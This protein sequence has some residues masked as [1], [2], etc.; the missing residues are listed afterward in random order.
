MIPNH[1]F[2]PKG[3]IHHRRGFAVTSYNGRDIAYILNVEGTNDDFNLVIEIMTRDG[4]S[5]FRETSIIYPVIPY[6]IN[7]ADPKMLTV[8]NTGNGFANQNV[9]GSP[10]FNPGMTLT[11][12]ALNVTQPFGLLTPQG[13]IQ[14]NVT[15]DQLTTL[16]QDTAP[17][18]WKVCN[19][20]TTIDSATFINPG[21]LVSNF[22]YKARDTRAS[23]LVQNNNNTDIIYLSVTATV[24][25]TGFEGRVTYYDSEPTKTTSVENG[26]YKVYTYSLPV[27]LKL[28]IDRTNIDS[29]YNGVWL[30]PTAWRYLFPLKD[31]ITPIYD[32][33]ANF[34]ADSWNCDIIPRRKVIDLQTFN[35]APLPEFTA[36]QAYYLP[37]GLGCMW[38]TVLNKDNASPS[39]VSLSAIGSIS[40]YTGKKIQPV[41]W[42]FFS[43]SNMSN[44]FK[45]ED[46]GGLIETVTE[47]TQVSRISGEANQGKMLFA[48]SKDILASSYSRSTSLYYFNDNYNMTNMNISN[49]SAASVCKSGDTFVLGCDKVSSNEEGNVLL[50]CPSFSAMSAWRNS[51][52]DYKDISLLINN[53]LG[54][55]YLGYT[56]YTHFPFSKNIFEIVSPNT[57]YY[58]N[59]IEEDKSMIN[60]SWSCLARFIR[61]L[62]NSTIEFSLIYYYFGS[63][64]KF[65]Y[66]YRVDGGGSLP[67]LT[68]PKGISSYG[69]D[70][71]SDT[72]FF[73]FYIQDNT[74]KIQSF[75][76]QL[77]NIDGTPSI[78][79]WA[80]PTFDIGYQD[81]AGVFITFILSNCSGIFRK[82]T[83]G[84]EDWDAKAGGVLV[85]PVYTR[86]DIQYNYGGNHSLYYES[87]G[88][89]Y[90]WATIKYPTWTLSMKYNGTELVLNDGRSCSF[91][92]YTTA[93][94]MSIHTHV[95]LDL[96]G[97][98]DASSRPYTDP[99]Y[100]LLN[101]E[102]N[103]TINTPDLIVANGV[104]D[105]D[106]PNPT[107][108]ISPSI[109]VYK[110]ISDTFNFDVS[111]AEETSIKN[112]IP[113][114]NDINQTE[115]SPYLL[116]SPLTGTLTR[117]MSGLNKGDWI[118]FLYTPLYQN[119][120]G[121]PVE[122]RRITYVKGHKYHLENVE[123]WVDGYDKT[124]EISETSTGWLYIKTGGNISVGIVADIKHEDFP[125]EAY[126]TL[127]NVYPKIAKTYMMVVPATYPPRSESAL[128]QGRLFTTVYE[129]I[130]PAGSPPAYP[131]CG[132][133]MANRIYQ[134]WTTTDAL[135][136]ASGVY[137]AVVEITGETLTAAVD[138]DGQYHIYL[139]VE[140][141]FEQRSA[142]CITNIA[143]NYRVPFRG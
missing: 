96:E 64:Y 44:L 23:I 105:I 80:N 99:D 74:L 16:N 65:V 20:S 12:N 86:P 28:E 142:W 9:D 87:G 35:T 7:I 63:E 19:S 57:K 112:I 40:D 59:E 78:G 72:D 76:T 106:P 127:T 114:T 10:I 49:A 53:S 89:G 102:Y 124:A 92:D 129:E 81:G 39:L 54:F 58:F 107:A 123:I 131:N 15:R 117:T 84:P 30:K 47:F 33:S 128:V 101:V 119:S 132:Y 46:D 34:T 108:S 104:V 22:K 91:V 139:I 50:K 85:D 70:G 118:S 103:L 109:D 95:Y 11:Y 26:T 51:N 140:D 137:G 36:V 68:T 41:K 88:S 136:K 37:V 100:E 90:Y 18:V 69:D 31:N 55:T 43:L 4:S 52:T 82:G 3:Y 97:V 17:K 120:R 5:D 71:G 143:K 32:S 25:M 115:L 6:R 130:P 93:G 14:I 113:V 24:V 60:S 21:G 48:V 29:K 138:T 38:D 75:D 42:V 73:R 1:G 135:N 2:A 66:N 98:L 79:Y 134:R 94:L 121:S 61:E 27:L 116:D 111:R 8:L 110:T 56:I 125:N 133:T 45:Y 67:G 62:Y 13:N 141:E 77:L 126:S 122:S 83:G